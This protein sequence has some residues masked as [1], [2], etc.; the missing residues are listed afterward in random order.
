MKRYSTDQYKIDHGLLM[1]KAGNALITRREYHL[2]TLHMNKKRVKQI[3]ENQLFRF[4]G[5]RFV[6]SVK[7]AY[8]WNGKLDNWL[9]PYK[10]KRILGDRDKRLTYNTD[11]AQALEIKERLDD[12]RDFV[13]VQA[14]YHK[15]YRT[16][17]S[18]KVT[19]CKKCPYSELFWSE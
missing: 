14:L 11:N 18:T 8:H 9:K 12:C 7:K 17:F 6:S 13:A 1:R 15:N 3:Q 16:V 19:L 4:T 2:R 10:Q 5:Y